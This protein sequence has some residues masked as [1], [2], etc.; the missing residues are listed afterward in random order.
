[1]P[2]YLVQEEGPDGQPGAAKEAPLEGLAVA[3]AVAQKKAQRSDCAFV[4]RNADTGEI[5]ARFEPAVSRSEEPSLATS[6]R[7]MRA[8]NDRLKQVLTD[9]ASSVRKGK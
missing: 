6:V 9:P 1:M 3:R 7:R 4:V 5:L 2:R 8:A